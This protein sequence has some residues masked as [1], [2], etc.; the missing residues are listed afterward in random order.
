MT[1]RNTPR[2]VA[3]GVDGGSTRLDVAVRCG[4]G[5]IVHHAAP[6][7]NPN[8]IGMDDYL[9]RLG[10]AVAEALAAAGREASDVASAGLGLA[11][12]GRPEQASAVRRAVGADMLPGCER[13]WIGTD[14]E[15]ALHQ[16]MAEDA[17][18]RGAGG[19]VL[20][21]GTGSIC[22]GLA[23]GR[24][25]V[26]VGGRGGAL[27]DEGSGF[28][29]GLRALR[30]GCAMA[31]GRIK[32][33][34]LLGAILSKL[35]LGSPSELEDWAAGPGAGADAGPGSGPGA[36][37]DA[38]EFRREVAGLFPVV[39]DQAASGEPSAAQTIRLAIGHLAEHA[40]AA[41]RE[42]RRPADAPP[43]PETSQS[44]TARS[45]APITLVCAGGLFRHDPEFYN[46][47]ASRIEE[48]GCALD[49]VRLIEPASLG[50]MALGEKEKVKR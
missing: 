19:I 44:D 34:A 47:F 16:G 30:T 4:D 49:P 40:L 9:A 28:W 13:I 7:A 21:A 14:A 10:R 27:G 41:E 8:L 18:A 24:E 15:A 45:D 5:R 46:S 32:K 6:G 48:R 37:R 25:P 17:G 23:A 36:G 22:Y 50:A 39:A 31:D 2:T 3:L 11:G 29:I 12:V 1:H 20:I 35:G 42:L 33:T 26:R 38:G 43:G